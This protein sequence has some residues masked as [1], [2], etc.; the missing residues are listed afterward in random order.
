MNYKTTPVVL[1]PDD[2]IPY[3]PGDKLPPGAVLNTPILWWQ[4]LALVI[5]AFA[6][7]FVLW[8]VISPSF[9]ARPEP[10]APANP[11]I[12]ILIKTPLVRVVVKPFTSTTS[13]RSALPASHTSPTPTLTPK[14]AIEPQASI[15]ITPT[16]GSPDSIIMAKVQSRMTGMMAVW[17]DGVPL[18]SQNIVIG[19][20]VLSFPVPADQPGQH[21]IAIDVGVP[22]NSTHKEFTFEVRP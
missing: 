8:K 16:A 4:W 17:W 12:A 6:T 7:V 10:A 22:G 5:T 2:S 9:S 15:A 3:N 21:T 14:P 13:P 18:A 11:R 20:N 19:F 1:L